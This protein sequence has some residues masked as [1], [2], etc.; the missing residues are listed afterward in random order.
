MA[1]ISLHADHSLVVHGLF[2]IVL[3]DYILSG[4]KPVA[5]ERFTNHR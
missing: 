2:F 3:I 5:V 4:R 1:V